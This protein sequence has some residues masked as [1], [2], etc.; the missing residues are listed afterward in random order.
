MTTYLAAEYTPEDPDTP[1]VSWTGQ[2]G[3]TYTMELMDP[4]W[5]GEVLPASSHYSHLHLKNG[6]ALC[7][8]CKG[9][10]RD[11]TFQNL[12]R[13]GASE[14]EKAEAQAR[15]RA[16]RPYQAVR[17]KS[18]RKGYGRPKGLQ[19]ATTPGSASSMRGVM[20]M[21][22]AEAKVAANNAAKDVEHAA[23]ELLAEV[24]QAVCNQAHEL[25][26]KDVETLKAEK[27]RKSQQ[28]AGVTR[29]DIEAYIKVVT[30]RETALTG[31]DES[32]AL[33]EALSHRQE[34]LQEAHW[35]YSD[36]A[37]DIAHRMVSDRVAER[38]EES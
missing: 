30:A 37:K 28:R 18:M 14:A 34:T 15:Y 27:V 8:K 23:L 25:A 4:F 9:P 22:C 3:V 11:D 24:R 2:G 21:T 20:C 36:Q 35:A 38:Q 13:L 7:P 31:F 16:L 12:Y 26:E 17:V 32:K 10:L 1:T 19:K 33:G 5:A 29:A 6:R